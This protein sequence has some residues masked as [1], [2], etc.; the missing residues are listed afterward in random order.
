M[1]LGK[2]ILAWKTCVPN[3]LQKVIQGY[4]KLSFIKAV[5]TIVLSLSLSQDGLLAPEA[6]AE[7]IT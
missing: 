5:M 6:R 4:E 1:I 3:P 7:T 2:V